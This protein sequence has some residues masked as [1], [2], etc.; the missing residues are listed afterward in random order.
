VTY[1]CI[2]FTWVWR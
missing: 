2:T 1:T